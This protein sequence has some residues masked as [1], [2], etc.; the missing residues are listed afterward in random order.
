MLLGLHHSAQGSLKDG[1]DRISDL[2]LSAVQL[3]TRNAKRWF[4]PPIE[5]DEVLGFRQKAS[6][7]QRRCL[8]ALASPL[9]NLASP[10]PTVHQRSLEAL[11][12]EMMRAEALGLAWVIVSPGNHGGQGEETGLRQ[13]IQSVNRVLERTRSFKCGLLMETGAGEE[14]ELG[15]DFDQLARLRRRVQLSSR[16]GVCL[17]TAKMFAAGNDLR[18]LQAYHATMSELDR[19]IGFR[20]VKACHLSDSQLP[21]GCGRR[22]SAHLGEGEIGSDAFAFI[23]NDPRFSEVPLILETPRRPEGDDDLRNMGRLMSLIGTVTVSD[24]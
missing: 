21:L 14:H 11:Y 6:R 19:T 23:V 7:F 15:S 22:S 1:L 4:T 13:A 18:D 20:N 17:D 10:D 9:I 2:Q 12:D 24:N 8:L 16:L 3:R 5:P